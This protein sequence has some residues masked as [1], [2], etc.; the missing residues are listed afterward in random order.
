MNVRYRFASWF[1]VAL[2]VASGATA[3]DNF[4]LDFDGMDDYVEVPDAVNLSGPFTFEAWVLVRDAASSGRIFSNRVGSS[5]YEW[6][7]QAFPETVLRLTIN[8][9]IRA[10][11]PFGAFIGE[12]THVAATWAGSGGGGQT[13][14][15]INGSE[16]GSGSHT[17][18]IAFSIGQLRFG[19]QAGAGTG[20]QFDG[21]MDE[22]RIW[23]SE[24]DA[25]TIQAWMSQAVT[26]SHPAFAALEGYWRFDEGTGQAATTEVNSPGR[27][28]RLGLSSEANSSDPTWVASGAVPLRRLSMGQLKRTFT[29]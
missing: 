29:D 19:R 23:S 12:W 16:A 15:Y 17:G 25:A 24:L 4:A 27:D 20:F 14:L 3:Q 22:L 28:G 2:L 11:A 18:L 1:A 5:G 7:V 9:D 21:A 10:T 8:G 6:D 13:T 26:G